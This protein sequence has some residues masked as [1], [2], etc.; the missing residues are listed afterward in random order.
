MFIKLRRCIT[1][2][3]LATIFVDEI[4]KLDTIG[5]I[6]AITTDSASNMLRMVG[7]V[8]KMIRQSDHLHT[9]ACVYR[10]FCIGHVL[11]LTVQDILKAGIGHG[12]ADHTVD[13][14]IDSSRGKPVDKLR[15]VVVWIRSSPQNIE[16]FRRCCQSLDLPELQLSLHVRTRWN[17]TYKMI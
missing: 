3:N 5:S 16:R 2:D 6:F 11:N 10:T 8:E 17:S 7:K 4:K 1:G 12:P 14:S 9:Q 13:M 15:Q